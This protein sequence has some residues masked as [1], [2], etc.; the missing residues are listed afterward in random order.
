MDVS[1]VDGGGHVFLLSVIMTIMVVVIIVGC[2]REGR[3]CPANVE[4]V[5]RPHSADP[6]LTLAW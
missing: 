4:G 1:C 3:S 2:R 6:G 5:E